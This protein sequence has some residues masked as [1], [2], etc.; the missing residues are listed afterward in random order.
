MSQ[1]VSGTALPK[2]I[3]DRNQLLFTA[4]LREHIKREGLEEF[5]AW[6]ESTDFFTAPASTRYHSAYTGGLCEH[7][8]NVFLSYEKLF[9]ADKSDDCL[10][11]SYTLVT[12][13][14]DI[15]KADFYTVEL[16]NRKVNNQWEKYEAFAVKDQFPMGHGEKSLYLVNKFMKLT[17]EE[18]LAIRWHMGGF[19]DAVKGGSY[20]QS[21]AFD[22]STLAVKVHMSDLNAS[23]LLESRN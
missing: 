12:L 4:L 11:E 23:Y 19:D 18:A 2:E 8:I 10:R 7:S 3:L 16:R 17:D 20:S 21:Q 15:C 6:L 22:M 9:S 5:I 1:I 14:H 13:L